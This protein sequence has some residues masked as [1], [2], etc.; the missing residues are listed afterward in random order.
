MEQCL[1]V[2]ALTNHYS[3]SCLKHKNMNFKLQN[4]LN[5]ISTSLHY[6]LFEVGQ[7]H[8]WFALFFLIFVQAGHIF[9]IKQV[10]FENVE[11]HNSN[12]SQML[13]Y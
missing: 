7:L 6:S 9:C 11:I 12:E 2:G 1:L 5:V 10:N 4:H 3:T 8:S 13:K